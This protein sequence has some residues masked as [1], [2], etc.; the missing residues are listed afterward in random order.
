MGDDDENGRFYSPILK[1]IFV[2]MAVIAVV[3]VTLWAITTFVRSYVEQPKPPMFRRIAVTAETPQASNPDSDAIQSSASG[4]DSG[5]APDVHSLSDAPQPASSTTPRSL[6]ARLPADAGGAQPLAALPKPVTAPATLTVSAASAAPAPLIA[7]TASGGSQ[8]GV[9]SLDLTTG[10]TTPATDEPPLVPDPLAGPVP[11][12]RQRPHS[13]AVAQLGAIPIP[14][15]RP[16][17][18]TPAA[19]TTP[20]N[21]FGWMRNI[22]Q[23]QTPSPAPSPAQNGE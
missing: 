15:P 7:E 4:Q 10:T 11:L 17:A 20:E 1:R 8:P 2:L 16:D 21:P 14:R 3:P 12:P 13:F 6:A 23:P 18:A 19:A 5:A 22:F 9:G